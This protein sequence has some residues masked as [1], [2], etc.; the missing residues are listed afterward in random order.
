MSFFFFFFFFFCV[1]RLLGKG[2][3]YIAHR[4]GLQSKAGATGLTIG[5]V[6]GKDSLDAWLQSC[7]RNLDTCVN[8][9]WE[10]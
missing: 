9:S 7:E 4:A 2:T 8:S 3:R 10:P 6:F 1:E 5:F